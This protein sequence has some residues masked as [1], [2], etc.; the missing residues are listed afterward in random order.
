MLVAI[1]AGLALPA[2]AAPVRAAAPPGG[3]ARQ[4]VPSPVCRPRT[5]PPVANL[6]ELGARPVDDRIVRY[7]FQSAA[8][9]GTAHVNVLFP[10]GYRDPAN[11]ET[12][13]PMLLLLHGH[14]GDADD[15]VDHDVERLVGQ[16]HLIVV[17][18]DGGY[19]GF[20]SDWYGSDL[21]GHTP[22]P[23]PAWETF[24]LQELLPWV[25][26]NLRTIADRRHRSIAGL[27]MGGFGAMSYAARHPDLFGSAGS[28]SGAVDPDLAWPAGPAGLTAAVNLPDAKPADA[29]IW[30][31]P[32]TQQV[33]WQAH[34]PT[35]LAANLGSV[36]LFVA[37][38]DGRPGRYDTSFD[39]GAS[40]IEAAVDAMSHQFVDALGRAGVPVTTWFYGPG[41]HSWPYWQDD[42]S[43]FL[44]MLAGARPS[45]LSPPAVPFDYRSGEDAFSVWDWSFAVRRPNPG[46]TVLTQVTAGGFDVAGTGL[47]SV[48]TAAAYRPG[49]AYQIEGTGPGGTTI[50]TAGADRRL[51][52]T[53]ALGDG[54]PLAGLLTEPAD[55]A[56]LAA[57]RTHVSIKPR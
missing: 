51:H 11:A 30:G 53:I 31:D 4:A 45:Q 3:A 2:V 17:M 22:F 6:T 37:S 46:F 24:H 33:R 41:T 16:R 20:Y 44:P 8:L 12:R 28:F 5:S 14:G 15:W 26:A 10:S 43:R 47:L 9:G 50:A 32:L 34:D 29:C 18:P 21:D 39:P 38:G 52:L 7:T 40:G 35:S 56:A 55:V 1:L 49:G 27:S 42:L 48:V 19:D 54:P 25:D 23:P 13:Y 57:G 36:R